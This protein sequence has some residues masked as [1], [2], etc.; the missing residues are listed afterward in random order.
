MLHQHSPEICTC[1]CHYTAP[2]RTEQARTAAI[3]STTKRTPSQGTCLGFSQS[4][5]KDVQLIGIRRGDGSSRAGR[6]PAS[7]VT[8]L[9]LAAAGRFCAVALIN[10][11]L[12]GPFFMSGVVT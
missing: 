3:R 7:A 11:G 2:A 9:Q 10:Q 5:L 8:E 1:T 6:S 4:L 12:R